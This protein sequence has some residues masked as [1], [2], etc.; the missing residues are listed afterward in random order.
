MRD[1]LLIS[2]AL[3]LLGSYGLFSQTKPNV[4]FIMTDQQSYN[5]MS[6][7]GNQ[8]LKTPNMDKMAIMGYRF[9]K[10]Y[11]ANPVCMPSRFSLLTGHY[12]SE[13]GVKENTS[14]PRCSES[15]GYQITDG[16][17]KYSIYE[18]PGHPELLTDLQTNPGETI[19]YAKERSYLD[20]KASLKKELM[21]NLSKRGLTPLAEN[22]TIK[23]LRTWEDE[24]KPNKEAKMKIK[25]NV[26]E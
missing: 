9:D 13:V 16:R 20:I 8:W 7:M 12:A 4:L 1:K 25:I 15:D 22:R 18:L 21:A 23:N 10:T 26:E 14:D 11:C 2:L 17:Y 5:M 6:C 24:K 19:N 3:P